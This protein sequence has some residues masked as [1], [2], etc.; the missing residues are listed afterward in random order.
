MSKNGFR[1]SLIACALL[2]VSPLAWG[3]DT[4]ERGKALVDAQCNSCHALTARVG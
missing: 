1:S 4:A 3:Q 2:C